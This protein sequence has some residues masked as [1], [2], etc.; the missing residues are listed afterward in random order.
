[1]QWRMVFGPVHLILLLIAF[2]Q[3]LGVCRGWFHA[4]WGCLGCFMV[5]GKRFCFDGRSDNFGVFP[6]S[7]KMALNEKLRT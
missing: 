3:K 7:V 6:L 2:A 5:K 1:M 4:G